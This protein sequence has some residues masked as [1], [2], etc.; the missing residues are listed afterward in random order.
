MG[1]GSVTAIRQVLDKNSSLLQNLR[2]VDKQILTGALKNL[3]AFSISPTTKTKLRSFETSWNMCIYQTT[4][5]IFP[6]DLNIQQHGRANRKFLSFLNPSGR[7]VKR[8]LWILYLWFRASSICFIKQPEWCSFKQ[9][10]LFFSARL[11]YMFRV[12]SAPIIRNTNCRCNHRY[13]S[14]VGVV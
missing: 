14:C 1:N 12:L 7:W 2:H 8:Y 5:H 6:E 13:S 4:R 10:Y 9:L 11:L 3:P